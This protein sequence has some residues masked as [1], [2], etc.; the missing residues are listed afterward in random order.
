MGKGKKGKD[1]KKVVNVLL[2]FVSSP[3]TLTLLTS[4]GAQTG[5][6]VLSSPM[7][8][9]PPLPPSPIPN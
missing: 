9:T 5:G 7:V 6:S 3:Q 4:H 8:P 1:A 2:L